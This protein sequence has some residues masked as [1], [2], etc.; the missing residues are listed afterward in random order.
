[1]TLPAASPGRIFRERSNQRPGLRFSLPVSDDAGIFLLAAFTAPRHFYGGFRRPVFWRRFPSPGAFATLSAPGIF[2]GFCRFRRPS[3][4]FFAALRRLSCV[5]AGR[6]SAPSFLFL[7]TVICEDR[8]PGCMPAAPGG[9]GK[10]DAAAFRTLT[11]SVGYAT[12]N[13]SKN[14]CAVTALPGIVK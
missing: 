12:I 11:F 3:A 4:L 6:R 10:S 2:G 5:T 8:H 1:M 7:W 9:R 14:R 13:H